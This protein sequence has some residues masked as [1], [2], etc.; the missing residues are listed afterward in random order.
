M[1]LQITLGCLLMIAT[2]FIHAA[3]MVGAMRLLRGLQ[4]ERWAHYSDWTRPAAV[5]LLVV[6]MFLAS[7]VEATLWAAM[8]CILGAIEDP[9]DALYFSIVTFT[10]LGYG[11]I[12]LD[13]H[14]R[15]LA[16][17]EAANGII[18]FGWT[19][20]VLAA[21]VQALYLNKGATQ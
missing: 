17:F 19:T 1:I 13:N 21:T 14:W 11:D 18:M 16:S 3:G 7:L 20:A 15:L 4:A 6:V 8:F 5:S 10:T 12:V 2:T 9:G